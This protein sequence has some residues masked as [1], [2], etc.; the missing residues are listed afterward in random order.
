[1]KVDS[2]SNTCKNKMPEE[3]N[4]KSEKRLKRRRKWKI[5]LSPVNLRCLYRCVSEQLCQEQHTRTRIMC[6]EFVQE[7]WVS[8]TNIKDLFMTNAR[9][10]KINPTTCATKICQVIK[11]TCSESTVFLSVDK[12]SGRCTRSAS[13]VVKICIQNFTFL[14]F[15]HR[16]S[17]IQ[18]RRFA[19][20]QRTL[21]IYLINKYI[22][23]SDNCL[24]V[25]H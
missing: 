15:R 20:L 13:G 24:P 3:R 25:H 14:T 17:S 12:C 1:M 4:E 2:E 9:D 23:L 5:K 11:T 22:S 7:D 10:W 19:T 21:F 16:A 8:V 18:D 6:A